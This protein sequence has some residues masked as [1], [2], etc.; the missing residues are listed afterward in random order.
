MNRRARNRRPEEP[1]LHP[2]TG[3]PRLYPCGHSTSSPGHHESKLRI[4][5]GR[6]SHNSKLITDNAFASGYSRWHRPKLTA[7]PSAQLTIAPFGSVCFHNSRVRAMFPNALAS[8]VESGQHRRRSAAFRWRGSRSKD[9][10]EPVP[11]GERAVELIENRCPAGGEKYRAPYDY[12]SGIAFVVR[13]V[14]DC[15]V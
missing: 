12:H 15:K 11:D 5:S 9:Q 14:M 13:P 8:A 6:M 10:Q 3:R 1:S 7:R 2:E 4:G